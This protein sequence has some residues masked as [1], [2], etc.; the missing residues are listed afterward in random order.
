MAISE[1]REPAVQRIYVKLHRLNFT[2]PGQANWE[3][4]GILID[5]HDALRADNLDLINKL[6]GEGYRLERLR[7]ENAGLR[8]HIEEEAQE[9]HKKYHWPIPRS[10]NSF[11]DCQ[12]EACTA[13]RALLSP[14]AAEPL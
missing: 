3:D 6:E 4:I 12:M 2:S 10:A 7:A 9:Y 1:E 5:A 8:H 11:Q 14:Q 13:A